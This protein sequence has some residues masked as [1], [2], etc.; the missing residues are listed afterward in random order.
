MGGALLIGG[1]GG[2]QQVDGIGKPP[3]IATEPIGEPGA[4]DHLCKKKKEKEEDERV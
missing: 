2:S 3:L 1:L 4:A